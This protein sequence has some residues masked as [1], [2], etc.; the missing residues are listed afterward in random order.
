M[1]RRGLGGGNRESFN[2]RGQNLVELALTMPVILLLL[3]GIIELGRAFLIYSEVSNAAREG[4]RYGMVH[5]G[6]LTMIAARA[7]SKVALVPPDQ[8]D[9]AVSYDDGALPV[10]APITTPSFG[11]RVVVTTTHTLNLIVPL[12]ADFVGPLNMEMASART[13][14]GA[15]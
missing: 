13:V 1:E 14:L 10:P 15:E 12:I 11:D 6:D 2:L 7:R 4:A 8:I 9:V 3:F 5:P